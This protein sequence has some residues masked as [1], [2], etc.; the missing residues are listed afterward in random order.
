MSWSLEVY[1]ENKAILKEKMTRPS[2]S[3]HDAMTLLPLSPKLIGAQLHLYTDILYVNWLPFILVVSG[4]MGLG[5][6]ELSR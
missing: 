1:R 3:N 6:I 2:P 4:K 5:N